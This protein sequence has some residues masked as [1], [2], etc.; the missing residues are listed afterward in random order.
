MHLVGKHIFDKNHYLFK[1]VENVCF[2]SK[3]IFN[4]ANYIIY[5]TIFETGEYVN[6]NAQAKSLTLAKAQF[7]EIKAE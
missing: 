2:L 7:P 5:Q 3:N 4:Y 1:K 6:Y